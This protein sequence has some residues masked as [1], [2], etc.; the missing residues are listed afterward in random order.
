[1]FSC[2][3]GLGSWNILYIGAVWQTGNR[4]GVTVI[5][6]LCGLWSKSL[7]SA[8]WWVAVSTRDWGVSVVDLTMLFWGDYG[9]LWTRNTVGG[10]KHGSIGYSSRNMDI[11]TE[12]DLNCG[13]PA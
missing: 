10:F 7:L 12:G 13:G 5:C 11:S 8:F 6:S 4:I 3:A 9:R 1:M 2:S